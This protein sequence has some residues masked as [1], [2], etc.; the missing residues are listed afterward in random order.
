MSALTRQKNPSEVREKTDFYPTKPN[1]ALAHANMIYG[2]LNPYTDTHKVLDVG[3]GTGVYGKAVFESKIDVCE[4]HGIDITEERIKEDL[5]YNEIY[6][7]DF[8]EYKFDCK[9][10]LI[11]GNPPYKNVIK[12][13]ERGIGLLNR[14]GVLSFLLKSSFLE[15][16]ERFEFFKTHRPFQVIQL[17]NRP[18]KKHAESY[19]I[20]NWSNDY[21]GEKTDS[22]FVDFAYI[23]KDG[24]YE[25][26]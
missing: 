19:C 12:F 6:I 26:I 13:V 5:S 7:A 15:S 9:Y 22:T 17:A 8:L 4:I 16:R 25:R 18:I 14:G 24:N 11:I 1:F 23:D 2:Q 10:D 20:V 21:Y 3:V